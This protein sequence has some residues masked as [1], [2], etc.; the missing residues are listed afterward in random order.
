[1]A[2]SS[3]GLRTTGCFF[4]LVL[5]GLENHRVLLWSVLMQESHLNLALK[6]ILS[7]VPM[8]VSYLDSTPNLILS[9]VPMQVS[10]L[11]STPNLILSGSDDTLI[12]VGCVTARVGRGVLRKRTGWWWSMTRA[13]LTKQFDACVCLVCQA[14]SCPRPLHQSWA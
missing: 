6:L 14:C 13:R 8:Q 7:Q 9:L 11:D 1:M 2:G 12:K 10:Y 5:F 3:G 4:G